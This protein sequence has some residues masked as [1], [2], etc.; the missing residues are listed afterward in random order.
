[1]NPDQNWVLYLL[2]LVPLLFSVLLLI[3]SL[4]VKAR[5]IVAP[6]PDASR[7]SGVVQEA[8]ISSQSSSVSVSERTLINKVETPDQPNRTELQTQHDSDASISNAVEETEIQSDKKLDINFESTLASESEEIVHPT[9]TVDT[10]QLPTIPKFSANPKRQ[11]GPLVSDHGLNPFFTTLEADSIVFVIDRSGSMSGD[12][13]HRV[14]A[15]LDETLDRLTPRQK[16]LLIFFCESY[17]LHPSLRHLVN[18]T[19]SNRRL[20]KS[21][22]STIAVGSGTVPV[23]A[24]LYAIKQNPQRIVLLS[25]GE[26]DPSD[27][28]SITEVNRKRAKPI[29]IDGIGLEENVLT[30]KALAE[31]NQG[32]YYSAK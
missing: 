23:D 25:D 29:R 10:Q 7:E 3:L 1:V 2:I 20:V 4:S 26:F 21:W 9:L 6:A 14:I 17:E 5:R 24:M 8:S 13:L 27:V 12:R 32:I 28:A 30:L 11:D 18:A 22:T 19:D 16:F 31:S 15:A